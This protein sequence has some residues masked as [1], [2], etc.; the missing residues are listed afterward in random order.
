MTT[1][2]QHLERVIRNSGDYFQSGSARAID[3][4]KYAIGSAL[5]AAVN[6]ATTDLL[7]THDVDTTQITD[8]VHY[9]SLQALFAMLYGSIEPADPSIP[10]QANRTVTDHKFLRLY[11]SANLNDPSEGAYFLKRLT[12]AYDVVRVPA[13]IASF[14]TPNEAAENPVRDTRDNLVFWRHYGQDGRGCSISIPANRFAPDRSEL[15]LRTVVYGSIDA[16]EHADRLR[17][18]VRLLNP[19]ISENASLDLRRQVAATILESLGEIPY[20]YKSS[21]YMYEKE[22]RIVALESA[23]DSYGKIRFDFD[24][25]PGRSGRLRMY[26]QHPLLS[27]TNILS[28]GSVITLGPA[29]PIVDN[30]QYAVEKLLRSV[31]I[32]G[33]PIEKSDRPYRR[34]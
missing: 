9:T 24:Q 5:R 18:I 12:E 6:E 19:I 34:T 33:V 13:Y 32:E 31:G 20:L 10:A 1:S 16:S 22:C 30:V 3:Y 25:R 15:T 28:T 17:P 7:P 4:V 29:V 14:V 8:V 27:L 11:D 2:I 26:G 21:A 23:F